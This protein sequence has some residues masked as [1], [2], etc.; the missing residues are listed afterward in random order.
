MLVDEVPW[1]LVAAMAAT[2]RTK[3]HL[4]ARLANDVVTIDM[5]QKQRWLYSI[6]W[7]SVQMYRFVYEVD[8]SCVRSDI[9]QLSAIS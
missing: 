1:K 3:Q 9:M 6:V 8:L 5:L 7:D 2:S 4:L